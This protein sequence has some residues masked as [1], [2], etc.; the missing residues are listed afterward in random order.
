[1]ETIINYH[2]DFITSSQYTYIDINLESNIL[3]NFKPTQKQIIEYIYSN[4]LNC[5]EVKYNDK[6][7]IK[8]LIENNKI[9]IIPTEI[10]S[11]HLV[12]L[13]GLKKIQNYAFE[14]VISVDKLYLPD[15]LLQI[16]EY[17][18]ITNINNLTDYCTVCGKMLELSGLNNI[19][20]CNN[21][22]CYI[23]SKHLVLD[24]AITDLYKKDSYLCEFLINILIDGTTHPKKE[25][26]FK[27][28]PVIKNISTLTQL[29][30]LIN[31]QKKNL[32]I[33]NITMSNND[34]E[35]MDKI[36]D[37]S[38]ALIKNAISNNFFSLN[39]TKIN[40]DNTI[41]QCKLSEIN[42]PFESK[43]IKIINFNYSYEIENKFKKQH[44]LFHGTPSYSW[45]PIIK[46][47][48]KVMSGTEFQ[49]NG[50]SYGNG[51]YFSD[52]FDL[53]LGYSSIS[54]KKIIGVFEILE[55]VK[56]Y[57]KTTNIYVIADDQIILLRYLIV[58]ENN[59]TSNY[60]IITDYFVKYLN[61]INNLDEKKST[62]ITNKR[63]NVEMKLLNSN[64]KISNIEIIEELTN[65][66][67][68][69]NNIDIK[70]NVYFKNF[71][72]FPPKILLETDLNL[73][74][75]ICDDKNNIILQ[76]LNISHWQV[77]TNLSKIIDIIYNLISNSI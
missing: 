11:V 71:P 76:E 54:Q 51:I 9:K 64:I 57:V 10:N 50:A 25:K 13:L 67:I 46:N 68:K 27:P 37:T 61:T 38:Y 5:I 53:S 21:N 32:N 65:W 23:Q 48:L 30:E 31:I 45:Y 39:T 66:K 6:Y 42:N 22:A 56:K 62:N 43:N 17:L 15:I 60:Q 16:N 47:G 4:N 69:L 20:C 63:L 2:N 73:N 75:K 33:T 77:T 19:S 49:A 40:Y 52:S 44:F 8:Y 3:K 70:L 34:I 72:I 7:I 12:R 29:I 55:D 58:I 18:N 26:I 35:L 14:L 28:L 24:N 59:D 41:I 1:M 74:K 36:N